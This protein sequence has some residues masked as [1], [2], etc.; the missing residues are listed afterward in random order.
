[1]PPDPLATLGV[2]FLRSSK[3]VPA[4]VKFVT[5]EILVGN[6]FR[7]TMQVDVWLD[8]QGSPRF[9]CSYFFE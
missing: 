1:M 3:S 8:F 4:F 9:I 6:D 5:K 2:N 7:K